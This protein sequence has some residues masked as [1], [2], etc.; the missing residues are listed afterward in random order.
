MPSEVLLSNYCCNF[1]AGIVSPF[2]GCFLFPKATTW[3]EFL[4]ILENK[5]GV[6]GIRKFQFVDSE[7]GDTWVQNEQEFAAFLTYTE[8]TWARVGSVDIKIH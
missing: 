1:E 7:Y 6:F 5:L 4:R 8:Q 2:A 3:E